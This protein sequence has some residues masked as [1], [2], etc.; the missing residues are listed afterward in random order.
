ME[1]IEGIKHIIDGDAVIIMGAGACAHS[2][3]TIFAHYYLSYVKF[4]LRHSLSYDKLHH[5][6]AALIF[7]RGG[8]FVMQGFADILP[9]SDTECP[10]PLG[11][12]RDRG[13]TF[14]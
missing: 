13:R 2:Y 9:H 8:G 4:I 7:S 6:T 11:F 14:R 5:K 12:P 1:L 10:Q 3:L